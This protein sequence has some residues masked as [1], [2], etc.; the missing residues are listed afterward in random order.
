M[1]ILSTLQSPY[2]V[3]SIKMNYKT[4]CSSPKN[5]KSRIRQS[6]VNY[7]HTTNWL[8]LTPFIWKYLSYFYSEFCAGRSSTYLGPTCFKYFNVGISVR[9]LHHTCMYIH[10]SETTM[11]Q[12]NKLGN[13]TFQNGAQE[14]FFKRKQSRDQNLK[15]R[16]SAQSMRTWTHLHVW[17]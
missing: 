10:L 1:V 16:F 14:Q 3:Q 4:V 12:K 2:L 13:V 7:L 17:N 9:N 8:P 6:Q 11:N 15:N 5:A